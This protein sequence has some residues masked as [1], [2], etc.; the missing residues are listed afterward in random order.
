MNKLKY[1]Y[2]VAYETNGEK[3]DLPDDVLVHVMAGGEWNDYGDKCNAVENWSWDMSQKFR[4]VDER[5]KPKPD[6]P[7]WHDRG[8]L[9]P[10]G[11]ECEYIIGERR[12]YNECTFVGLNSRGS[13][14]IEDYNGEYKS[15][16]S[17]Q[18]RFRPLH[19]ERD[20]LVKKAINVAGDANAE[21][22][23][24]FAGALIDA[25]WRPVKQQTE[26]EFITEA[27]KHDNNWEY[28]ASLLYR[29][30]CRFVEVGDE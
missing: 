25:G 23:M 21:C 18:I 4:I 7:N 14:V 27:V 20:V 1:E 29:A 12:G 28:G 17:H 5:Y 26:D 16:H 8:E 11:T 10:A 30:G 22:D 3:P 24:T 2:G 13:I 15:Y 19:T 6:E 9:P